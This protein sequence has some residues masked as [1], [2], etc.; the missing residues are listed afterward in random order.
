MVVRVGTRPAASRSTL[1]E[2]QFRVGGVLAILLLAGCSSQPAPTSTPQSTQAP[3]TATPS[4]APASSTSPSP[5]PSAI[6]A[7]IVY[8][9]A[10]GP[11]CTA[12]QLEVRVGN[13]FSALSNG[14]TYVIFTD[15]GRI[16]C[17]LRHTPSVQ[18][19]DA[20]G[21]ALSTPLIVD[22]ASGYI[23]TLPNGGV[24]LLPLPTEGVAPGPSPEGGVRG[25]AS[26]PF[27]YSA[28]GCDNSIAAVRIQVA[29]GTLTVRMT[30][31]G[32]GQP[33]QTTKVFINPFQP[34]EFLP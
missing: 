13:S 15:R 1:V 29:A 26:L 7:P 21:R 24:G 19:L 6:A 11:P 23:P 2:R 22:Q 12:S 28:D 27:Q 18:F 20:R 3:L 30:L 32:G 25:Q 16:R 33:C 4:P 8:L 9:P 34:A 10:V 31:S 5:L 14:I 17:S